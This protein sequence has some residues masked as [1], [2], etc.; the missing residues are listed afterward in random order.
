MNCPRQELLNP[1]V[2]SCSAFF[3]PETYGEDDFV[4]AGAVVA[5]VGSSEIV[6]VAEG[7]IFLVNITGHY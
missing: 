5:D 1:R 7:K 4:C 6:G 2:R 3:F